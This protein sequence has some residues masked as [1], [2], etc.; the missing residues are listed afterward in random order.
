MTRGSRD[1][2]KDERTGE[3]VEKHDGHRIGARGHGGEPKIVVPLVDR[4]KEFAYARVVRKL[5]Q[6]GLVLVIDQIVGV[7]SGIF[8]QAIQREI[9]TEELGN[10]ELGEVAFVGLS[11]GRR[12]DA[13]LLLARQIDRI[14]GE[15]NAQFGADVRQK[16]EVRRV[17]DQTVDDEP[18][19]QF[20]QRIS[21]VQLSLSIE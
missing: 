5:L 8:R 21:F 9:S 10:V 13:L 11:D 20:L 3:I 2:Q 6:C 14:V 15:A 17:L 12:P 16:D 18:R 19:A 4:A 7:G 1:V